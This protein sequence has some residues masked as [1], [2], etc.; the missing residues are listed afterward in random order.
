LIRSGATDT[1]V[2]SVIDQGL[3]AQLMTRALRPGATAA[4]T[5]VL[6]FQNNVTTVAKGTLWNAALA[7]TEDRPYFLSGKMFGNTFSTHMASGNGV[8]NPFLLKALLT[9]SIATMHTT[10]GLSAPRPPELMG[11]LPP[12]VRLRASQR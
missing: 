1:L 8:H 2:D 12:G 9:S 4:D 6:S 7:A 3:I 5:A 10:Y 11:P